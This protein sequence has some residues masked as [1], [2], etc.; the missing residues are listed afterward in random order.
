MLHQLY[1]LQFFIKVSID[2]FS[3]EAK[4]LFL[5]IVKFVLYMGN[6]VLTAPIGQKVHEFGDISILQNIYAKT[7]ESNSFVKV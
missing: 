2:S 3:P 4:Y 6:R 1:M 5:K 7:G